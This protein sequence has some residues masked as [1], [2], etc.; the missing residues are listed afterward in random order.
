MKS[1]SSSKSKSKK[2]KNCAFLGSHTNGILNSLL[3]HLNGSNHHQATATSTTATP[4]YGRSSFYDDAS[5][6]AKLEYQLRETEQLLEISLLKKKLRETER[7]MEQIIADIHGKAAKCN[8]DENT[9]FNTNVTT[10]QV[11][12]SKEHTH[13]TI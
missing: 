7:A 3:S 1:Q 10:T 5:A 11:R 2:K 12:S 4:N 9:A 13:I 8:N 6:T